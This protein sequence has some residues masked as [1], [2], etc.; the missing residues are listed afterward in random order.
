VVRLSLTPGLE[1]LRDVPL[2]A[3]IGRMRSLIL[4]AVLG[5]ESKDDF[6]AAP[7]PYPAYDQPLVMREGKL[8][9]TGYK[10]EVPQGTGGRLLEQNEIVHDANAVKVTVRL[11]LEA[12]PMELE[13]QAASLDAD[14]KDERPDGWL[15]TYQGGGA[16]YSQ[17]YV[18]DG[19]HT[20]NAQ[21]P[22]DGLAV[23]LER[24]EK[25][26][27]ICRS[28]QATTGLANPLQYPA[29][30]SPRELRAASCKIAIDSVRTAELAATQAARRKPK[31]RP[32][33]TLLAEQRAADATREAAYADRQ[34]RC[35][36]SRWSGT[37]L[38]CVASASTSSEASRCVSG[39]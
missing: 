10:I 39:W 33:T 3:M 13:I 2:S 24:T 20:C 9:G 15:I 26:I 11:E 21:T 30:A 25:L 6:P 4:L 19:A 18:D 5:C 12:T 7:S 38:Q 27:R 17:T 8:D 34:H 31:R 35:V 29:G 37:V 28:L 36:V 23:P 32:T 1:A 22:N 14:I 16:A